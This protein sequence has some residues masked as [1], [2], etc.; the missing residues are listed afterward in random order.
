LL[1]HEQGHF[2]LTELYARNMRK[3]IRYAR[4]GCDEAAGKR[5]LAPIDA[6]WVRA[7]RQYDA[8][9]RDGIDSASQAAASNR[10]AEQLAA[11]RD[12]RN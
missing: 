3:I 12:Y 4:I 7:E 9:T 1:K 10:I 8:E 5:V 11:L 6:E 2:D